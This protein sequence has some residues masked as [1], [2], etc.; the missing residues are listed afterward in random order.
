[1]VSRIPLR[2]ILAFPDFEKVPPFILV[3]LPFLR[4]ASFFLRFV[5]LDAYSVP[6]VFSNSVSPR[7]ITL[8]LLRRAFWSLALICFFLG[9]KFFV[10]FPGLVAR[11]RSDSFD[12]LWDSSPCFLFPFL[13]FLFL[14]HLGQRVSCRPLFS[15]STVARSLVSPLF[16]QLCA[17]PFSTHFTNP[18][19]LFFFEPT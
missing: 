11:L 5:P 17:S 18:P 9:L 4:F 15:P 7:G 6:L 19:L 8:P 16:V 13:N 1:M 10:F 14:P 3:A 2:G 12:S